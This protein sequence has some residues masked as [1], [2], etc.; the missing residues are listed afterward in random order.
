MRYPERRSRI[1]FRDLYSAFVNGADTITF[2]GKPS[3]EPYPCSRAEEFQRKGAK[4]RRRKEEFALGTPTHQ[5]VGVGQGAKFAYFPCG[6]AS[7]RLCVKNV[8]HGS[9]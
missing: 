9:G 3:P 8:L 5:M 4:T 1:R 2:H 6:S 7:L